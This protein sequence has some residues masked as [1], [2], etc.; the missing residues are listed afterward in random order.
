M[1]SIWHHVV[2]INILSEHYTQ[3]PAYFCAWSVEAAS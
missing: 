3:K 2:M 1:T